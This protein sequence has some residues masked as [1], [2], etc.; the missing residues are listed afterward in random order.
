MERTEII[1]RLKKHW[2]LLALG[3]LALVLLGAIAAKDF[4]KVRLA[5]PIAYINPEG[6]V[7]VFDPASKLENYKNGM[8]ENTRHRRAMDKIIAMDFGQSFPVNETAKKTNQNL[9]KKAVIVPVPKA[10]APRPR[11]KLRAGKE[12][13]EN[14]V[15]AR[16]N[17]FYTIKASHEY[18]Y[19]AD[20]LSGIQN[21]FFNA[22]ING[23][24]KLT[25]NATIKLR[26][27]EAATINGH[28]F[29]DNT[30]V[31]GRVSG[32]MGG[33]I[34]VRITRIQSVPVSMAVFDN[35]FQE[36][37]AY[38][39]D[40]PVSTAITATKYDAVDEILNAIPY[41]GAVS[42]LTDLGKNIARR[43]RKS[44]PV[45]LADG[46]PVFIALQP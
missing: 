44:R 6:A 41:G 37:I 36:G 15:A 11:R 20:S 46:Y 3:C 38:M 28:T 13:K 26:L 24:Q 4:L 29:S 31:Y 34:K 39:S 8:G 27:T 18:N 22:V 10:N 40:E 12:I 14:K 32:G 42:G 19:G 5:T 2:M 9:E 45:F 17:S 25:A 16:E 23:D 33:R 1:M 35:D 30:L 43:S 21:N 7:K